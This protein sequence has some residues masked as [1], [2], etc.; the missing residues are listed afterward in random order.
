[1]LAA[2]RTARR[3][4]P[5]ARVVTLLCDRAERYFST[6]LFVRQDEKPKVP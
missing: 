1:V 4:G 6:A 2:I 5:H 3:L